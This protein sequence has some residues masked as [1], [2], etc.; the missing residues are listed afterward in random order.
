LGS[1]LFS[2]LIVKGTK[3]RQGDDVET[4]AYLTCTC[5]NMNVQDPPVSGN[6]GQAEGSGV[7]LASQASRNQS[8]ATCLYLRLH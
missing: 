8:N 5:G 7:G 2:S 4:P 3:A 6:S 1:S